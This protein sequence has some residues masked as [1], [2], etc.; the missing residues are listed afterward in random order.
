[1]VAASPAAFGALKLVGAAYL[2]WLGAQALRAAR[3]GDLLAP[4]TSEGPSLSA[5]RAFRRGLASDLANV[6]VGLF[7]TAL[8]PQFLVPGAGPGPAATMVL[9]MALMALAGMSAFA[10]LAGRLRPALGTPAASRVVN[11]VVGALLDGACDRPRARALSG[12]PR[13]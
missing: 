4:A 12:E 9:T 6:K 3:R 2:A 10:C 13:L 11:A 1:M 8:V 5:A 7:W